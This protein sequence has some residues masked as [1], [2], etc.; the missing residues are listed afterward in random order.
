MARMKDELL[1]ALRF[2]YQEGLIWGQSGSISVRLKGSQLMMTPRGA[3]YSEPL[4][5][6]L[7]VYDWSKKR[8]R[9]KG[10]PPSDAFTHSEIYQNRGQVQAIFQSQPFF[11]TL[12]ACSEATIDTSVLP[13]GVIALF[14]VIDI[15]YNHPGSPELAASIIE[16]STN[17]DILLLRNYGILVAGTSLREVIDR[18][19]TFEFICKLW[20]FSKDREVKLAPLPGETVNSLIDYVRKNKLNMAI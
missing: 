9:G 18:T 3:T 5:D 1:R 4:E 6:N 11:A 20:A 13:N 10:I 14:R 17:S 15:P 7:G 16:R 19:V 12:L 2:S 8:W